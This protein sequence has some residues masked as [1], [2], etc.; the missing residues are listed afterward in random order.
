MSATAVTDLRHLF[1]KALTDKKTEKIVNATYPFID[2]TASGMPPAGP[3]FVEHAIQLGDEIDE[4]ALKK[5]KLTPAGQALTYLYRRALYDPEFSIPVSIK[6]EV[7]SALFVPGHIAKLGRDQAHGPKPARVMVVGKI[8]GREELSRKRNFVGGGS[9]PLFAAFAEVGIGE[10]EWG[11]WYFTNVCKFGANTPALTAIPSSWLRDCAVLLAQEM[12]LVRPDFIL[13]LGAEATKVVLNTKSSVNSLNGRVM[14]IKVP[15]ADGTDREVKVMT[16]MH[17]AFVARK[18]EAYDEFRVQIS[19]FADLVHNQLAER[20]DVDHGEIY[21]VDALREVV[22]EMIKDTTPNANIIAIDCEWHGDHPV[23]PGSYLRTI[24]ISNKDKWA[25]TIVLR[26]DGGATAFRPN[27]DAAKTELIRLLKSTPDRHVRVGGHFLRA[28]LPWLLDFGVDVRDEYAPHKDSNLRTLGGWD[29]SLMYHAYNECARYGL[30][31]CSMRFTTAPSYW[32][33]LERWR[34]E[35]CTKNKIKADQMDGYGECPAHVLHPYANYDADVT[36]R[37]MIKFYGTDGKDGLL[38]KDMYGND[39]WLP[40]WTA[41]SASLPFLEMEMTGMV[42]DRNRADELT[43]MFM[44][45]QNQLLEE[46]R[47][48]LNWPAFNPKSHPQMA[49]ALFGR[50]F[51]DRFTTAVPV[52]DDAAPLDLQPVK[53][54]G[55]RPMLWAEISM[56]G[57]DIDKAIPSTDKESLGILGH[58]NATAA[59]L[60]DYKFISQVLQSVLRKPNINDDGDFETDDNG[61]YIYEKGLVGCVHFDG[62]VRTHLFQTKETGRAS[63]S[64]PPLQNLSSRRE[65]DYGRIFGEQYKHPVRSILRVPE[66]CVGIESDLT[67]AELAVLAWLAQDA[68]MIEHVRRNL[69][70]ESHPDHYDIHSQQAIKTFGLTDV[71]PTKQGMKEAGKKS[72]R[73]AA[74]N[75]NFGIP[76]G[77][78]AEALARQCKEEGAEVPAEVCQQMIEAYF[79]SYPK[80][81]VFLEQCR[82]RSQ[83]PGWMVG[84]YGRYRRFLPSTDRAVI[85]EQQR[86]AQNFPIQGGVADA[87]SLALRNF[88]E[89]RRE[90][91]E[92]HYDIALQI[93]DAIVLIVPVEHAEVVYKEV[94]PECMVHRLPFHPR[95]LNGDLIKVEQP[96]HFG[97]SRDVFVHW[98]EELEDAEAEKLGLHWLLDAS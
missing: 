91:P 95:Y 82:K 75:V 29:T 73:I 46:L 18:P 94:I 37:I 54:T 51:T 15:E 43:T 31:E 45:A 47:Q 20:E 14:T 80:T 40:Y 71:V 32:E 49:V 79:H 22:D 66:G 5:K 50:E 25:R 17:P 24:Q 28:D 39:C 60:R 53:T 63:S 8:P 76:Y 77:R 85:G 10:A 38:S 21:S 78:G 57:G 64:R 35:Y 65:E 61:H 9:Q 92:I 70:P 4:N 88:Y 69:L 86:Q 67:G 83:D 93:H 12:R 87:V 84:P 62:K 52:P 30:D 23:N 2:L 68:N 81:A 16:A 98:G 44:T 13:C 11:E 74:K 41:H 56:R 36:R 7:F 97:M 90:H 72:L 3:D 48:D 27:L 59:K 26:Y 19:R 42:L 1:S 96:Y 33:P 55:K 34:K 58:Q 6:G 89:Y